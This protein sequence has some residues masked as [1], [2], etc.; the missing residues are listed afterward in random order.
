[1]NPNKRFVFDTNVLVS[2]LL[3]A[4]SKPAQAFFLAVQTGTLLTSLAALHELSDVLR[5]KKFDTYLTIDEREA[6]LDRYTH[7]AITI[8]VTESIQVCRDTKD[9]KF[10]EIAANGQATELI[11]GD[12]D[13]L[14]LHPFRGISIILPNTFLQMIIQPPF[15]EPPTI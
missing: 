9:D 11:T 1:M 10:L 2:A 8:N 7:L 4:E 6:F 13:L 12:P 5:R 15:D 14:V 3:F